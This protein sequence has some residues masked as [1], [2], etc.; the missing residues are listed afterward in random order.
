M[1]ADGDL[2]DALIFF[3]T[4]D[5]DL[6]AQFTKD[7]PI[8]FAAAQKHTRLSRKA[9]RLTIWLAPKRSQIVQPMPNW[10]RNLPAL[11]NTEF[12]R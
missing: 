11:H 4:G 8:S 10:K 3:G 12:W 5:Q 1:A 6:M 9:S 2:L 7:Y